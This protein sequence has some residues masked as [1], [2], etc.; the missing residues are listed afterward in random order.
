MPTLNEIARLLTPSHKAAMTWFIEHRGQ[1]VGW[2]EQ[3]SDGTFLVNRPK[4][5]H[6]P[7]GWM[8]SLSVRQM[9]NGPYAD[10]EP[11]LQSDGS[12]H[13]QYFQEGTDPSRRDDYYTNVGLM[14][15]VRDQVPIG[16]LRQTSEEPA[17]YKV[18]GL[19]WVREWREDGYFILDGLSPDEESFDYLSNDAVKSA[20]FDPVNIE[21]GRQRILSSII[22][23]QGQGRFRASLL[24]A[25]QGRCAFTGCDVT[26]ALEAA[27]IVPYRGRETNQ[28]A[29]G[30]LL[31]ADIHTL[32]DLGLLAID[33]ETMTIVLSA[34]LSP[35]H[36]SFLAGKRMALPLEACHQPSR[37]AI[38]SHRAFAGL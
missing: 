38:D 27:H 2:P 6:K 17:R 14:A 16:V 23:R 8:Y 26:S 4:G 19:A 3:L 7:A 18:M 32:F 35:G 13:Y 33:S 25:Y 28:A 20:Q 15:C 37:E 12:W 5:I 9:M 24:N 30:I 22:Q 11:A 34:T 36:Y 31:R 21:D 1:E 10:A 29:N